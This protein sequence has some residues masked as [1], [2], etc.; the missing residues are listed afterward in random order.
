MHNTNTPKYW[1]VMSVGLAVMI[2]ASAAGSTAAVWGGL[3]PGPY[4]VGFKTIEK[5]DYSRTFQPAK[6]YYGN[7]VEG[8]KGRPIQVCIWY[9]AVPT[10][11]PRMVFSEY[12]F[13]YPSDPGFFP[14]LSQLQNREF[15]TLYFFMG[16]N[17]AQ[18]SN[19]MNLELMAVRDAAEA[20]GTFPLIVYHG[21]ERSGYCQNVVMCE[22]LASHGFVVATTH[23]VG[24]TAPNPSDR[25]SD[26]EAV[27]RDKEFVVASMREQ[28]GVDCERLGLIGYDY[29]GVTALLH[30]MRNYSVGAVATLQGRIL[31]SGGATM[32][33]T[34]AGY[35][36]LRLQAPWLQIYTEN[37]QMAVDLSVVDSMKY[38]KRYS[39]RAPHLR[40]NEF[41]TY[42]VMAAVM[43]IDTTRAPQTVPQAHAAVCQYLLKFFDAHL[44]NNEASLAWLGNSPETNGF[45]DQEMTLATA[46]GEP[47]PPTQ[48]QFVT[49]I[50]TY[51]LERAREL[52]TRFDLINPRNPI[53]SDANFTR[54]GYEFLLRG[55]V[56]PALQLFQ[57]GVTAYPGSANAW[58]SYGE[59]CAANGDLELALANYRKAQETMPLDSTLSPQMRQV[60][61]GNSKTNIT[62]L[63]QQISERAGAG[64]TQ[65]DR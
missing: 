61:E 56:A 23:T 34:N 57:W 51:G 41:S 64:G 27:I 48:D 38:S 18:V 59:A 2:A 22:Y 14:L 30:Q 54:L 13:P 39:L 7:P 33:K 36:P 5:Y 21:G 45:G 12:S 60:L 26:L 31:N 52:A 47:V 29:G 8:G 53:L 24:M 4:A 25:Q 32:L 16:N 37:P 9:P 11:G 42:G 40:P 49:I 43:G 35:E 55:E 10:D 46:Q 17:Q 6:D 44:R 19:L 15:N 1:Y 63:E 62:R 3:E 50:Q 20:A 65:G 28:A 58:D